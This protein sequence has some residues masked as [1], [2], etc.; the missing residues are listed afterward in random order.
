M[1]GVEF[2]DKDDAAGAFIFGL[3]LV[4]DSV[5]A[6]GPHSITIT[7]RRIGLIAFHVSA[8]IHTHRPHHNSLYFIGHWLIMA[9]YM[10]GRG[11][12]YLD[13]LC[14]VALWNVVGSFWCLFKRLGG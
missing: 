7:L 3:F 1:G 8:P 6:K 12:V 14:D 13:L 9:I 4:D 5:T 10:I 11:V 2:E